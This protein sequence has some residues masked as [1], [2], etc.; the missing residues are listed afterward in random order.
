MLFVPS[1]RRSLAGDNPR[2][3]VL[4]CLDVRRSWRRVR[5]S[6]VLVASGVCVLAC[7]AVPARA[8]QQVVVANLT[9]TATAQNTTN[10]E[11]RVPVLPAAPANWKAP[12]D[13][14][15]GKAYARF[16]VLDKP[17][18]S[19]TLYNV[20][21]A[22]AGDKLSCM[23][24]S[25]PYTGKGVNNISAAVNIFWNWD[26]VDWSMGVSQIV[27][28]LK[29]ESGKL[30]Q[31][32]A[33]FYPTTIKTTVTI[34]PPG[35]TYVP[36]ADM[37]MM[38][39]GP[40]AAGSPAPATDAGP[41]KGGGPA[42]GK[43]AGS[44]KPDAGPGDAGHAGAGSSVPM[45]VDAGAL[46]GGGSGAGS[47]SGSATEGV[48]SAGASSDADDAGPRMHTVKD[49]LRSGANCSVSRH[50]ARAPS[51]APWLF[52]LGLLWTLRLRRRR[53]QRR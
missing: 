5:A 46:A 1:E 31:G 35:G 27:L 2:R 9:Y 50:E 41:P 44:A 49:Y 37:P 13:F 39:A 51:A 11:Y 18:D 17:S 8:Q 21:F 34:V 20:C 22:L 40:P 53:T 4:K 19:K 16:E 24:L 48:S 23:P 14:T 25:P 7:F 36:P 3:R 10:S 6:F 45:R 32:D 30:V 42:P 26:Q 43:D 12:V 38:D 29:D 15:A 47:N 52:G 28:V 33:K